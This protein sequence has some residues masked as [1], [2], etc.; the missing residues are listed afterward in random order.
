MS[1]NTSGLDRKREELRRRAGKPK[2][3]APVK[4]KSGARTPIEPAPKRSPKRTRD[5]W[6]E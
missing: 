5:A 4:A 2:K 1:V 6:T 3:T